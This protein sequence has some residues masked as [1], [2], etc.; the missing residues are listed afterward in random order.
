MIPRSDDLYYIGYALSRLTTA[1][2]QPPHS[3]GA[4]TWRDAYDSFYELFGDGRS[5]ESF[6]NT[7]KNVRDSFDAFRANGPRQ[8]W[9]DA[10]GEPPSTGTTRLNA[11]RRRLDDLPDAEIAD[12]LKAGHSN[13]DD[14]EKTGVA[15]TE[16]GTR[17]FLSRRRERSAAARKLAIELHGL[18]CMGCGFN[19][20]RCYGALGHDF[21]EVHHAQALG[22][23]EIRA[24]DPKTD[25]VVLCSNCHRMVHRKRFIVLSLDELRA[26]VINGDTRT[27]SG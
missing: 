17:L 20:E 10:D 1:E 22:D 24:T 27:P 3:L 16:G 19:F 2:G 13:A 11:F 7:L 23:G 6:R 26:L 5:R 18:D 9:R 12:I 25:L 15:H 21:I 8:G 4:T 14:L